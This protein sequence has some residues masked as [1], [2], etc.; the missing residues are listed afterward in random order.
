MYNS[1]ELEPS[2]R[3]G[4]NTTAT[5]IAIKMVVNESPKTKYNITE[6]NPTKKNRRNNNKDSSDDMINSIEFQYYFRN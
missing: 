5:T 2:E 3:S 6:L 1:K 4:N